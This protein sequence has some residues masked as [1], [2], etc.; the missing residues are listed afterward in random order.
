MSTLCSFEL[1]MFFPQMAGAMEKPDTMGDSTASLHCAAEPITPP[2][3]RGCLAPG[4][5][6]QNENKRGKKQSEKAVKSLMCSARS[7][8]LTGEELG[9]LCG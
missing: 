4:W 9:L 5:H 8:V 2:K 1:L 7:S 6:K 3:K